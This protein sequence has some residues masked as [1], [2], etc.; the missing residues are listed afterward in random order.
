MCGLRKQKKERKKSEFTMWSF[1]SYSDIIFKSSKL[2]W[3]PVVP[4]AS[5]VL[6]VKNLPTNAGDVRYKTHVLSLGWEDPLE[7][8]MTAH[9]SILAWR[10][11]CTQE[12]GGLQST[13]SQRVQ[14]AH[15]C[16]FAMWRLAHYIA[17]ILMCPRGIKYSENIW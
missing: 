14:Q 3:N 7:E 12:P 11:P 1:Y 15:I 13:G 4:G 8:G 5:Q 6:V 2:L 16:S 9:S 17:L 10:I